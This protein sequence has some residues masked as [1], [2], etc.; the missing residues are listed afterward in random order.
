MRLA[1]RLARSPLGRLGLG[2]IFA[3]MSFALVEIRD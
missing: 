3:H 1:F 2:W